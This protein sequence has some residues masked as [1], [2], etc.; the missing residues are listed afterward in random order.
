MQFCVCVSTIAKPKRFCE[1]SEQNVHPFGQ[2]DAVRQRRKLSRV[3][4]FWFVFSA[5]LF[6]FY[7]FQSIALRQYS[8]LYAHNPLFTS[9]LKEKMNNKLLNLS[10]LPIDAHNL[11]HVTNYLTCT[12]M[13]RNVIRKAKLS[14]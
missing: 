13:T 2:S 1:Q 10:I 8:S 7:E 3:F 9:Q 14:F 4:L 11:G 6:A 5:W 12:A